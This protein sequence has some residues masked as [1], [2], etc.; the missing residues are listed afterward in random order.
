MKWEKI[1]KKDIP[2]DITTFALKY[3]NSQYKRSGRAFATKNE[4]NPLS[5]DAWK[6]LLALLNKYGKNNLEKEI[7]K[8]YNANVTIIHR[9]KGKE[10]EDY[11]IDF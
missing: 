1:I 10:F 6:P 11:V 8:L 5:E 7:G 4:S 3:I 2:T 9:M